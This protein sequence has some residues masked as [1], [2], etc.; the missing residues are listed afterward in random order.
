MWGGDGVVWGVWCVVWCVESCNN[1]VTDLAIHHLKTA[2]VTQ[3]NQ[4][5]K[6]KFF[7]QILPKKE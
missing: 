2:I 6:H 4:K 7:P 5:I 1:A 3:Q